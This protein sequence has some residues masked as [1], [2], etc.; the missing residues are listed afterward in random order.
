MP[1][2]RGLSSAVARGVAGF[3]FDLGTS[4]GALEIGVIVALF[5]SGMVSVQ[6]WQYFNRSERDHI[7][8]KSIVAVA[9]CLDVGHSIVI[10]HTIYTVT[11]TQY[12][13][14]ELL[15][16]PPI[17]LDISILM[18]GFIGPLEQGWFTYRLWKLTHSPS[19]PLFC[20]ILTLTRFIGIIGLSVFALGRPNLP[21]YTAKA[22][23]LIEFILLISAILD[24]TLVLSLCYYLSSWH[25]DKS[26][27]LHKIVTQIMTWTIETGLLTIFG[28][29]GCLITF[30]TMKD[31]FVYVAFF[32]V[33]PK[34]FTN[35]LLLSLNA[36]QGYTEIIFRKNSGASAAFSQVQIEMAHLQS[37]MS[38]A[39]SPSISLPLDTYTSSR[40]TV[41]DPTLGNHLSVDGYNTN[42]MSL[43]ESKLDEKN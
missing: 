2:L 23:W 14:P 27:V 3:P 37:G 31:N 18:S 13:H 19:L 40:L 26:R 25:L 7:L 9:W 4:I 36:R 34:L 43:R 41:Q 21:D 35:S 5:L 20:A 24:A 42:W 28:T 16:Q 29:L 11:V 12:G 30:L 1:A 39:T 10:C 8:V 22:G 32:V 15:I 38:A 17:T 33:I 6:A